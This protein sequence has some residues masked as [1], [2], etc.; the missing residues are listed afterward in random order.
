MFTERRKK[1]LLLAG[2]YGGAGAAGKLL[3]TAIGGW[4][5]YKFFSKPA[6]KSQTVKN[7]QVA[8]AT[9]GSDAEMARIAMSDPNVSAY[10]DK[11]NA[12]DRPIS[13][14]VA[15]VSSVVGDLINSVKG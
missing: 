3:V 8:Q 6:P 12:S 13:E 11:V 10:A 1:K 4:L 2:I 14:K 5:I 9:G 15:A 7:L